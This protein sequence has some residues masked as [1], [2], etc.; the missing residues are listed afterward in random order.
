MTAEEEAAYVQGERRAWVSW[1]QR[2]LMN[3][4]YEFTEAAHAKW[5]L[6]REE[7]VQQLRELCR[8]FGD[9]DWDEDLHLGDHLRRTDKLMREHRK[10]LHEAD[11]GGR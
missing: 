4:G 2:C 11:E 3:L 9:N 1:L 10:K 7:L 8:E 5:I 6:E